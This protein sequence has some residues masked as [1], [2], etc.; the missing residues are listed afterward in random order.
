MT[1]KTHPA[2]SCACGLRDGTIECGRYVKK[3][4]SIFCTIFEGKDP[5]W[6]VNEKRLAKIGRLLKMMV[7]PNGPKAGQ[8][9]YETTTGYQWMLYAAAL[10][11]VS[12]K[13]R[14]KRRY[15]LV[16][17]E[18][19]RK[20]FK[21]FTIAV[22]FIL[23]M[24]MEPRFSRL[25]SVA[26]DG[27][28]SKEVKVAVE[29][30]IKSSPALWPEEDVGRYFKI[31]RTEVRC[32]LTDSTFTPLNYST[33]RLDGR[34]PNVF[35]VDEA[36]ALPNSY[37]IEA[38]SSG[39]VNI[40]NKLGFII[41]TKYPEH[42]N[43]F[44]DQVNYCKK[45]LDGVEQDDTLFCL[46]FEPDEEL[47]DDWASDDRVILQANPAAAD[48]P[49]LW[50]SLLKRR[51][52]AIAMESARENFLCKHCNIVYQGVGTECF[53]PIDALQKCR[54]EEPI[55]W[56]GMDVYVGVDLAMS[57]DNCAVAMAAT[58]G[59]T[60]YARVMGF[61]PADRMDE[62]SAVERFDYAS[63]VRRGEC[64]ACGDRTV[65]YA[66]IEDYVFRLAEHYGVNVMALG[67]DRYNAI[68]SAQKWERGPNGDYENAITCVQIRQHSDTLHPAFKLMMELTE[69]GRLRYDASRLLEENFSNARASRDTN[70]NLY[71]NK[72]KS[73]GKVDAVFALAN[74]L[75][76]LQQNTLLGANGGFVCQEL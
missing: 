30:I 59:E 66:V 11:V 64:I 56:H 8:T 74:A 7:M 41:S 36:G 72:K 37:A 17:M 47:R 6:M 44:E 32:K 26:P 51:Q 75:Y 21:T 20:N 42:D 4:A 39:Q 62:K 53:I 57:N 29:S 24:L 13:D 61:L 76:L 68:S 16:V 43:P 71:V 3:Q 14:D 67:Y 52:R 50:S 25:F 1:A 38:M 48:N 55:D 18:I 33:N 34:L 2:Y 63:A 46:L 9:I 22:L 73:T 28:L 49:E 35:L 58:D 15:E 65:D 19:A 27:T 5:D 31:L 54:A 10:C 40:K 60:V 12:R 70:L 45:V 69:S 23:L